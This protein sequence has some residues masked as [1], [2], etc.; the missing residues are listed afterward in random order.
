MPACGCMYAYLYGD[1]GGFRMLM[2]AEEAG[3]EGVRQS[4]SNSIHYLSLNMPL[5]AGRTEEQ[6]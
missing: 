3:V 2:P 1:G 5:Y 6:T 4:K